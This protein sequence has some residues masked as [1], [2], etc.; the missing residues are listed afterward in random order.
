[1]ARNTRITTPSLPQKMKEFV[2]AR[3]PFRPFAGRRRGHAAMTP[4][5]HSLPFFIK[6][7]ECVWPGSLAPP[8]PRRGRRVCVCGRRVASLT[9]SLF[10]KDKCV[11]IWQGS[12]KG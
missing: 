11:C 6:K 10:L 5:I 3:R 8:F 4:P 9:Y 1:M 7:K 2:W 12:D